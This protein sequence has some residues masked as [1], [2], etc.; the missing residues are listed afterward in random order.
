MSK[1]IFIS[2]ATAGFGKATAEKFAANGYKLILNGRRSDRLK[3]LKE[4]LE[5]K[6][7]TEVY[8]LPFD[9]QVQKEVFD[10]FK[11]LPSECQKIDVVVNNAGLAWAVIIQ[12]K[13]NWR[14]GKP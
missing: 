1:I 6:Y 12:M 2:G 13:R 4:S 10:A 3:Q 11:S 9:V 7:N 5:K 14:T 8:N